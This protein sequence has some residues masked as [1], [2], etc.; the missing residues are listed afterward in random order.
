MS[1]QAPRHVALALTLAVPFQARVVR[2]II[3][4][5]AEH[6]GWTFSANP[7]T[8]GGFA[9]TVSMPM[10]GLRGWSGDGVI[11]IITTD[12]EA[13]KA[14]DLDVPVV[15]IAGT[16]R[17]AGLPRV[18]VD[19]KAI[20]RLAARHLLE[21]GLRQFAYLGFREPW[22]S[23]LRRDGFTE[24]L[25]EA[26][27][28]YLCSVRIARAKELLV[29]SPKLSM[30]EIAAQCGYTESQQFRQQFRRSE[31]MSPTSYRRLQISTVRL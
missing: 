1:T 6:G 9:E 29:A 14:R 23:E 2:G 4:Y 27:Y 26:G 12:E 11:A 10:A 18:M 31:K 20:G 21:C 17:D 19:Q 28:E 25:A 5:A 16:L 8:A 22:F 15:N 7:V 3:D 30:R 13:Q 24:T